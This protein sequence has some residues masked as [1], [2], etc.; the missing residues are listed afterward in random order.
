MNTSRRVAFTLVELLIVMGLLA[1]LISILLPTLSR[2]RRSAMTARFASEARMIQSI[3]GP[4]TQP[5]PRALAHVS[6][7]QAVVGLTPQLSVGTAE[8][9]SIYESTMDAKLIAR[10]GADGGGESEIQLPLPPQII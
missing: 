9:E 5:V 7:F 8:P 6:S 1:L 4:G 10:S 3:T 2:A